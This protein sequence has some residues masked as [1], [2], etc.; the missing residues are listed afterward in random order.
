[1]SETRRQRGRPKG[2][3]IDDSI[4]LRTITS[5]LAGNAELKPTTAIRRSGVTDP[6]VVRRLREKLKLVPVATGTPQIPARRSQVLP[7]VR[8]TVLARGPTAARD[9]KTPAQLSGQLSGQSSSKSSAQSSRSNASPNPA[10]PPVPLQTNPPLIQDTAVRSS[11]PPVPG[12]SGPETSPAVAPAAA[13]TNQTKAQQERTTAQPEPAAS[14]Q[15]SNPK[16]DAPSNDPLQVL[17]S[18][19]PQLEALRLSAEAAA[20]MSRLYLHCLNHATQT[21]PLSLALSGQTMMSQWFASVMS[22]QIAA[23][24]KPKA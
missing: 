2:T 8:P 10:Q 24:Q 20:A 14:Q 21:S 13:D 1:M 17:P 16:P 18:P 7:P 11:R 15:D 9:I 6:S 19:D 12:A 4:T 23:R 5:L 22:A 3:G